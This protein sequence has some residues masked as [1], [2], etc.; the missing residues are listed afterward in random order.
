V[1]AGMYLFR[2][3]AHGMSFTDAFEH[4]IFPVEQRIT[5][6]QLYRGTMDACKG[7]L[8]LGITSACNISLWHKPVTK[9]F[10]KSGMRAR[11][12][13]ALKDQGGR[14]KPNVD[15]AVNLVKSLKKNKLVSGM[16]GI[17]NERETSPALIREAVA[18]A[19]KYKTGVHMHVAEAVSE[20]RYAEH[21]YGRTSVQLADGLGVLG[22]D[23][24]AVHCVNIHDGDI[25][26]LKKRGTTVVHC[27]MTNSMIHVG[28]APV[29]KLLK[30][31]VPVSLGTDDPVINEHIDLRCEARKARSLHGVT[32]KQA[33]G[34]LCNGTPFASKTGSIKKGMLADIVVS[35][36][37][38]IDD[39][40]FGESRIRATI[41]GGKP[42]FEL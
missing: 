22:K 12:C 41:V 34:M 42:L 26:L 23:T 29:N 15:D 18:L 8:S 40:V 36:A 3:L 5:D 2:G 27:P 9:A 38:S 25:S 14:V 24:L 21:V 37:K 4:V 11:L 35:E 6:H 16:F 32:A 31:G 10:V 1:H 20:E 7:M 13:I 28:R 30:A 19:K 17:A 39:L 33:M